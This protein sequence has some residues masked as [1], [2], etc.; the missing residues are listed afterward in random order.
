MG[1]P[2]GSKNRVKR[3]RARTPY[4]TYSYWYDKYTKG[5]KAK[6][7]SKKLSKEEFEYWYKRARAKGYSNPARKVAMEQEYVER[8]ME[9]GLRKMYGDDLPDLSTKEARMKYAQDYVDQ[10]ILDG[11]SE[12]DAWSEFREY[13]Y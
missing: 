10:L 1:R 3:Q 8:S 4:Q 13:F 2:K 7:F 6:L 9:R 11:L 12:E 5:D